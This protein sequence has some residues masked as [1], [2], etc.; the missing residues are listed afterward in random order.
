MAHSA[1]RQFRPRLL[2]GAARRPEGRGVVCAAGPSLWTGDE[3]APLSDWRGVSWLLS[4]GALG[5]ALSIGIAAFAFGRHWVQHAALAGARAEL[6][7]NE[8]LAVAFEAMRIAKEEAEMANVAKSE[9]LATMSHELR[10]PLNAILGFSDLLME[11]RFGPLG[12]ERY[13]DYARD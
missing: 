1:D 7:R 6:K 11:Q 12:T 4:L 2:R 9:F 10:T 8:D 5:S 13:R 3:D